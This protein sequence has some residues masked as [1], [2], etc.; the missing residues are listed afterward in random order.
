MHLEDATGTLNGKIREYFTYLWST[1]PQEDRDDAII[2]MEKAINEDYNINEA[3]TWYFRKVQDIRHFLRKLGRPMTDDELIRIAR[4][5][6]KAHQD[7]TTPLNEW[8]KHVTRIQQDQPPQVPTWDMFKTVLI[9]E[10]NRYNAAHSRLGTT[11]TQSNQVAHQALLTLGKAHQNQLQTIT[12]L[13]NRI[14]Q[15][16]AMAAGKENV[17][18]T[19]MEQANTAQQMTPD[20]MM[21]MMAEFM[22]NT[23]QY[24][25]GGRGRQR[26]KYKPKKNDY[27]TPR[28]KRIYPNSMAY[29]STHG[30][31]CGHDNNNCPAKGPYHKPGATAGDR[32]N[33]CRLNTHL[34]PET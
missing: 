18:P 20:T 16:E 7:M 2:D 23:N 10:I 3:P 22:K 6:M 33:G 28:N 12:E 27:N 11:P 29:C 25:G 21:Q 1:I 17:S 26:G 14:A 8:R 5:R 32:K 24:Q 34:I 19:A 4:T 31:D 30:F 13:N 9:Q 15:L